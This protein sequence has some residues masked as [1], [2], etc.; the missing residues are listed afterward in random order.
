MYANQFQFIY[1][2]SMPVCVCS[3]TQSCLTLCNPMD[4]SL[5]GSSVHGISQGRIPELGCHF[6]LQEIFPTQ[7]LNLGLPHCRQLLY[8]LSHR[9]SPWE[10]R[11]FL[12]TLGRCHLGFVGRNKAAKCSC[13]SVAP[14][15][16]TLCDLVDCSLPGFPVLHHLP[17]LAQ[18][19]VH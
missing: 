5:L 6:L 2:F 14:S 15:C 12:F 9:G 3:V 18:T 19:H 4:C 1:S 8:H 11:G 13:C 16:L 17:E 10:E 7:G